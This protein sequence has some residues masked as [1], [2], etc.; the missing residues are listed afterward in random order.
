MHFPLVL[1]REKCLFP[2]FAGSALWSTYAAGLTRPEKLGGV[3][4]GG[5]LAST[6]PGRTATY[7][8]RLHRQPEEQ[9]CP[10]PQPTQHG[11]HPVLRRTP[12]SSTRR[13]LE[14]A[15]GVCRVAPL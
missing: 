9:V 6:G 1:R 14:V 13:V 2:P 7:V 5:G 12:S 4:D 3:G 15:R 8:L 11:A 10:G